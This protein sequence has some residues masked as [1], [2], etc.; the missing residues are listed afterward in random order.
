MKKSDFY[1]STHSNSGTEKVSGYVE[2]IN[3]VYFGIHWKKFSGWIVSELSTGFK[4]AKNNFNS[5]KDAVDY[6]H[7]A[8][9]EEINRIVDSI[10]S[11]FKNTIRKAYLD[12]EDEKLTAAYELLYGKFG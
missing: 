2:K 9:T 11:K 3:G 8:D 1:I 5:K 6:I 4:A 10:D 7:K 12:D